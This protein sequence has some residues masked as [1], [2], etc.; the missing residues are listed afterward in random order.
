MYEL[1]NSHRYG[2]QIRASPAEKF[3]IPTP[4]FRFD[5]GYCIAVN[6]GITALAAPMVHLTE[7]VIV[8]NF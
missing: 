1:T 2:T 8:R 4:K 5:T 3:P 6:I 7:I